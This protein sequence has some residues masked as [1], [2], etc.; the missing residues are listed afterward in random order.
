MNAPGSSRS[1][2][3]WRDVDGIVLFDKPLNLSS[4][5]A[6]QRVRRLYRAAKAGHTGSLDPLATGM[7][8]LCLGQ[9]TKICAYLLD[10]D[11]VYRA[12]VAL[13]ARTATA[14]A[15]GEVVERLPVPVADPARLAAA[16]ASLTGACQQVPPMYSALKVDGQR[17]YALARAGVEVERQARDIVVH[18]LDACYADEG[19]AVD[20]TVHCSKGTYV[21]TL[22]EDLARALGTVGHLASLRREWVAPFQQQPM[23]SLE[24]LE[25][26]AGNEAALDAWL[27]P[28]A[29]ALPDWPVVEL[30]AAQATA[31]GF[32]RSIAS[33]LAPAA[34]PRQLKLMHA[35]VLLALGSIA[36][37]S[38]EIAPFRLFGR[39]AGT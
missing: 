30:D 15:E 10:S 13:G 26:L 39:G 5:H 33:S 35:G 3:S 14:D 34:G 9:A 17:L 23:V 8:P 37:G 24:Q 6:L 25:A 22:G 18:A 1:R 20:F 2:V 27:L 11:K 36:E 21:R 28:L 7:L 12:R 31:I 38:S 19:R 29:A 16:V 32:G 4:N